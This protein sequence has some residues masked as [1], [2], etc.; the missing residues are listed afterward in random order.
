[1]SC[2]GFVGLLGLNMPCERRK[3][4]MCMYKVYCNCKCNV[5]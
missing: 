2:Q 1:M 5:G 4:R 3:H